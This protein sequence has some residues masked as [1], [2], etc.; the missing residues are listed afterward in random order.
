LCRSIDAEKEQRTGAGRGG[1]RQRADHIARHPEPIEEVDLD[2]LG[3]TSQRAD[4]LLAETHIEACREEGTFRMRTL[5][6]EAA[7][8]KSARGLYDALTGFEPELIEAGNV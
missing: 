7:S 1:R 3:W 8:L 6:I 5:T 4:R 2:R